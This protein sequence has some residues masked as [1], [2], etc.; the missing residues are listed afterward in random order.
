MI[1]YKVHIK[2][3]A[4]SDHLPIHSL[5]DINTQV[6][7]DPVLRHNWKAMDKPKLIQF[8]NDNLQHWHPTPGNTQ[9]IEH[10][11]KHLLQVVQ[12]RIQ[13]TVP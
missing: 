7:E 8:V 4:D 9:Q 2:V 13:A 5:I 10:N 6:A 11:T 3:H 12:Q 1:S